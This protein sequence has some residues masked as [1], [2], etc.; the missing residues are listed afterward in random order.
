[1]R[2]HTVSF[3]GGGDRPKAPDQFSIVFDLFSPKGNLIDGPIIV[4]V[5]KYSGKARFFKSP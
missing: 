3:V 2:G 1:M 4:L 5:D